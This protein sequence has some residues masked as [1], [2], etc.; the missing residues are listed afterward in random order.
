MCIRDRLKPA[1]LNDTLLIETCLKYAK[2]S[3]ITLK[4]LAYRHSEMNKTKELLVS[5]IIQIVAMSSS[6]KVKRINKV[7]KNPF[8]QNNLQ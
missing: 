3:S 8:F 4:Q 2:N 6:F 5:G 7:L 1:V